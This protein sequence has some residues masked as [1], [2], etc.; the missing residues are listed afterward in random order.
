MR[1]AEGAPLCQTCRPRA[2]FV[3]AGCGRTHTVKSLAVEGG[4][5]CWACYKRHH[6]QTCSQCGREHSQVPRRGPN[7]ERLCDRCWD[8]D[9]VSCRDC[10]EPT[11]PKVRRVNGSHLCYGCYVRN[12][13]RRTCAV[14]GRNSPVWAELPLGPVCNACYQRIRTRP[15]P[16]PQCG[17]N[18]PL[19]GA[20]DDDQRVC[21]ACC[22]QPHPWT[23]HACGVLAAPY[24]RGRCPRCA[25]QEELLAVVS[26][27]GEPLEMLT[28]LL[29]FFDIENR[30]MAAI[31]WTRSRSAAVLRRLADVGSI[32][33]EALDQE[34][35]RSA[36]GYLR[37][38]LVFTQVLPPRD[39]ELDDTITWL[40]HRLRTLRPRDQAIVRRYAVWHVLRRANRQPHRPATRKHAR[41]RLLLAMRLLAWLESEGEELNSLS[42]ASFDRWLATG[43]PARAEIRDFVRWARSQHLVGELL[44]PLRRRSRP[45][46]Y[47]ST[48]QRWAAL[49]RCIVDGTLPLNLRVAGALLLL[50]ALGPTA[51]ATMRIEQVIRRGDCVE[52]L[53]GRTPIQLPGALA[54]LVLQQ[55]QVAELTNT[56]WL[57]PGQNP[58]RHL[59]P[60][61]LAVRIKQRLD[62]GV[63][64]S[65]NAALAHLAKELPVPVLADY[66]GLAHSTAAQWA[67]LVEHQWAEYIVM[68]R[69]GE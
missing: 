10:G 62:I 3:C 47:L 53:V 60:N 11:S 26:R 31:G 56:G 5:L 14:C 68:R 34:T 25:A 41:Q 43:P 12:R 57:F 65:R 69:A 55:R 20:A 38:L 16:C 35:N 4:S 19:V 36:A 1:T 46:E 54:D 8:P 39:S 37:A 9:P 48:E 17:E 49:R 63:R 61:S 33:H 28:L 32:T 42:Q 40:V 24:S 51:L 2:A 30:P 66:L 45:S 23:C 6:K 13:P 67:D 27:D 52:L 58:G 22:G 29:D 44:V 18:R 7:G 21:A 15:Q 64:P 50:F 59:D